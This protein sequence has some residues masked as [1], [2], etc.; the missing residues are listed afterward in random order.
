[1]LD[2]E[3]MDAQNEFDI[4]EIE[5][6]DGSN[7]RKVGLISV[8]SDDPKLYEHFPEPG[9]FG[10]ATLT[11]PWEALQKYKDIL[12]GPDHNCDVC[13]P[14][15]HLYVPDD[16]KTCREFDFPVILSGHDHHRVDEV[17]EGTRLLKPGM[18]AVYATV[19]EMSWPNADAHGK[20]PEI[21]ATF[22]KT[23]DWEPD[24]VLAEE[25]ERA[26][27]ALLPLRNTQLAEVPPVFEPLSS[28]DS[29]AR[30]CTMGQYICTLL[31]S[32]LNSSRKPDQFSLNAL[33]D[34][35]P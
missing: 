7:K 4:V 1:M 8:L 22:V 27:D 16:H 17:V 3:A 9:A 5:S 31:R 32:S 13:L 11:D 10:G 20:E 15:Q 28:V 21:K 23:S 12:E 34:G 19:L 26:Y 30:V 18:D 25:N 24:P 6:P 33:P 35:S 2:H 29:R 14:L